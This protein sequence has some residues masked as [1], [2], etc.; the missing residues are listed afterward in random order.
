M[1][2]YSKLARKVTFAELEIQRFFYLKSNLDIQECFFFPDLYRLKASRLFWLYRLF[3]RLAYLTRPVALS[4]IYLALFI[5][6]VILKARLGTFCATSFRACELDE[7][8]FASSELGL[9]VSRK[10]NI[11]VKLV[12]T[13]PRL[14]RLK[15]SQEQIQVN[16]LELLE[17]REFFLIAFIAW[18]E[19]MRLAVGHRTR[20][21]SMMS[22]YLLEVFVVSEALRK[23]QRLTSARRLFVTDHFDRWAMMA[24][25][26]REYGYFQKLG[27][28]QHGILTTT[29]ESDFTIL[30]PEKLN[31]VDELYYYHRTSLE[32]FKSKI[33]GADT[34]QCYEFSNDLALSDI[35][36]SG[37]GVLVVGHPLCYDFHCMLV[38]KIF[39]ADET[40]TVFYKPHPSMADFGIS[41]NM[42]WNWI[43]N[44]EM[45]PDVDLV[46]SYPSSLAVQYE[47]TATPV[48]FHKLDASATDADSVLV[49]VISKIRS[50]T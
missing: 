33:L 15:T 32:V 18:A 3:S 4:C 21:V 23:V 1:K 9:T 25:L 34:V 22:V 7:V 43:D 20:H 31:Y 38:S 26:V 28:I 48:V 37:F 27:V 6:F 49:E 10:A 44:P 47:Q 45:F 24:D 8:L 14:G 41:A 50:L 19:S 2:F 13:L 11:P 17:W 12:L 29:S 5:R 46:V 40:V 39:I 16:S 30:I 42:Q 35:S 36:Y